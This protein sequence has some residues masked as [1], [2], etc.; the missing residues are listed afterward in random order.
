MKT[1]DKKLDMIW[2]RCDKC[3]RIIGVRKLWIAEKIG[4]VVGDKDLCWKCKQ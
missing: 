4:W 2:I 3:K 1:E